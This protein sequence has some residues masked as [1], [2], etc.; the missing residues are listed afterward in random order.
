MTSYIRPVRITTALRPV[1]RQSGGY[2]PPARLRLPSGHGKR[3]LGGSPFP[4]FP[5]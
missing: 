4:V 3:N 2:S 1:G 5:R